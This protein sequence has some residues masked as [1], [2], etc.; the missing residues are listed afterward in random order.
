MVEPHDS[1][2]PAVIEATQHGPLK[3]TGHA[4]LAW[5][6]HLVVDGVAA[7]EEVTESVTD[8]PVY[9]CRCGAS[10]RKPFCDGSHRRVGFTDPH[11]PS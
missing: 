1:H 3:V 2:V 9:L 8:R 7:I 5:T 11:E 6:T 10:Q 4:T